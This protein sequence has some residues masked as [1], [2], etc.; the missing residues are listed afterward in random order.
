MSRLLANLQDKYCITENLWGRLK[1]FTTLVILEPPM[2]VFPQNL[3]VP[4]PHNMI[5]FSILWKFSPWNACMVTS[6]RSVKV[7]ALESFLY[8]QYN[9]IMELNLINYHQWQY[10][11]LHHWISVTVA[12]HCGLQYLAK[13]HFLCENLV[14][15]NNNLIITHSY[16]VIVR[17]QLSMPSSTFNVYFGSQCLICTKIRLSPEIFWFSVY[18]RIVSMFLGF[19]CSQSP[20]TDS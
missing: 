15:L 3:S 11:G 5:D 6:Y 8:T 17:V 10:F 7:F 9:I 4:Y 19:M 14:I 1:T 2:K 13:D 20:I 18:S 12:I 16:S